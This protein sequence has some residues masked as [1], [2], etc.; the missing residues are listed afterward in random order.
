M[1]DLIESTPAKCCG[2]CANVTA[3]YHFRDAVLCRQ[4]EH[5]H[6]KTDVCDDFKRKED[7]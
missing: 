6:V 1:T 2:H 4:D 7:K 5:Y 3:D